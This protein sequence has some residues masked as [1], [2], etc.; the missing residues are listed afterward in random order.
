MKIWSVA[1]EFRNGGPL[2][3]MIDARE[4]FDYKHERLPARRTVYEY[5]GIRWRD[6]Q[7]KD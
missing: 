6:G 2:V 4:P 3:A 5:E 7:N 1:R